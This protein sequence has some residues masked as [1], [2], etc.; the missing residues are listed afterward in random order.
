MNNIDLNAYVRIN[1]LFNT[2]SVVNVFYQTG[3]ADNNG[4]LNTVAGQ[5]LVSTQGPK[6]AELYNALGNENHANFYSNPRTVVIGLRVD[7]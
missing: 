1:N 6:Y 3:V 5:S 4:F 2:H 7:L